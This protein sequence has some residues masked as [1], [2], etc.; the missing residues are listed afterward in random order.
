[1]TCWVPLPWQVY[2]FPTSLNFCLHKL[3]RQNLATFTCLNPWSTFS[4]NS[5][6]YLLC[7][8]TF[9]AYFLRHSPSPGEGLLENSPKTPGEPKFLHPT[10]KFSPSPRHLNSKI[11]GAIAIVI[12]IRHICYFEALFIS[13]Q[14]KYFM[15][16][17]GGVLMIFRTT[18]LPC[19]T[20]HLFN[21]YFRVWFSSF[22]LGKPLPKNRIKAIGIKSAHISNVHIHI[23]SSHL[24][25]YITLYLEF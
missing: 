16:V 24:R 21:P 3:K 15:F 14:V 6:S 17:F 7:L 10:M 22:L 1:M 8:L 5:A 13:T 4:S 25:N 2:I 19:N 18:A 11:W 12:R 23:S 20:M 9:L